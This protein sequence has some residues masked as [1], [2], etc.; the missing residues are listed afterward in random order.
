VMDL[1]ET[2]EELQHR[3]V[4]FEQLPRACQEGSSLYIGYFRTPHGICIDLWGFIDSQEDPE[5]EFDQSHGD[6]HEA[7]EKDNKQVFGESESDKNAQGISGENILKRQK[8]EENLNPPKEDEQLHRDDGD[9]DGFI[10]TEYVVEE[11]DSPE[12]IEYFN[13]DDQESLWKIRYS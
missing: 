13:E 3:G 1:L 12:E 10:E 11:E 7:D 5:D 4:V 9:A 2:V 6:L 8:L